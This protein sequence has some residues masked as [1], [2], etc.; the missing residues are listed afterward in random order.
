MKWLVGILA[1]GVALVAVAFAAFIWNYPSA[2]VRYRLTL[3]AEVDGKSVAGSGVV[4]VRY[5]TGIKFATATEYNVRVRG[6]AVVLDLGAKGLVFALLRA[7]RDSRSEPA[8]IVLRAFNF[9]GGA[10]P[11]P[12]KEGIQQVSRLS[13]KAEL[14]VTSL[15]LLVRFRDVNDPL[16]VEKVDPLDLA[17]SFGPDVK[18]T[19]ATL[20]IVSNRSVPMSW[21][22]AEGELITT[23]I[24]RR[25]SWLEPL[26]GKY[27]DGA[28]SGGGPG[29][30]NVLDGGNFK[31]K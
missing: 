2:V 30:S 9:S 10:M 3:Y 29:L 7:G 26:N 13:G 28:F 27:L 17:A 8:S 20:E 25:L 23:G 5:E 11:L 16:T 31:E 1:T 6:E 22:E 24:Q 19:R 14:P 12:A 18:L 21:I 15:P 4:E